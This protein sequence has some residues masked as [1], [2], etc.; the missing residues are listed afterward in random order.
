MMPM[1][2][3]WLTLAR[4]GVL[5]AP[6]APPAAC[7][8]H[9]AATLSCFGVNRTDSTA[10]LQGAI[11][12]LSIRALTIDR[13]GSP[14]IVRPIYITR[15][16]LSIVL[17]PGTVLLAKQDEFHGPQDSLLTLRGA[18]N[19]AITGG[20]GSRLQMRRADYAVPSWCVLIV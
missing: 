17:E 6:P 18:T 10:L 7:V 1:V 5:A 16:N 4:A 9:G 13:V 11:E 2:A 14:W 12:M 15:A 20:Q 3:A 8:V 19:I